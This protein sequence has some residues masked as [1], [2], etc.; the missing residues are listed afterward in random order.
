M[1]RLMPRPSSAILITIR[2]PAAVAGEAHQGIHQ[3]L[4]QELVDLRLAAAELHD[5]LFPTLAREVAHHERHALEDLTDLD[6]AHA[7]H[8]LAQVA[9]LAAHAQARLLKR[10]PQCRRRDSFELCQLIFKTRATDH[11]LADDAHQLVEPLE[12]DAHYT[13]RRERYDRRRF[14]RSRRRLNRNWF[15]RQTIRLEICER[16]LFLVGGD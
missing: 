4:H 14:S 1:L 10:T 16:C 6:H 7:H 13:R 12:I 2:S 15:Q 5:D 11:E 8:T 9:Q 3:A